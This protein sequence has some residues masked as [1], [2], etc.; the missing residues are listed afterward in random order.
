[1]E[2]SSSPDNDTWAF[3]EVMMTSR[4]MPAGAVA[5]ERYPHQA[6]R[7]FKG[8]SGINEGQKEG[9]DV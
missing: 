3:I 6:K 1:M 5:G 2:I 4:T 8:G 9:N 7:I